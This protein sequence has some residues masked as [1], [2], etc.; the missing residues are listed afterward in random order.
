MAVPVDHLVDLDRWILARA[1][2]LGREL[3]QAYETY[4]FHLVYQKLHHFC[5]VD[6]GA[7][8]LDVLKDRLYTTPVAGQPRRS[9]QTALWHI[10]EAMVRWMAPI[11]SVTA[12]EIWTSLPPVADRPE[13]VFLSQWHP[14]PVVGA[15]TGIDWERVVGLRTDLTRA[16][17][18]LRT[19]GLI[20]APLEAAV[21]VYAE[22]AAHAGLVGL[23]DELRFALL[24]SRA[25]LHPASARPAD[26]IPAPAAGEGVYLAVRPSDGVK[27]VRCWHLS[28]DVGSDPAHP[29][30]CGR[31]ATNVGGAG[32]VRRWV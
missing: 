2:A 16:L 4:E 24:T 17:E 26:A 5:I 11:L 12:E 31:C 8:Y 15:S 1:H 27:C 29:E 9:A 3:E 19:Q 18:T 10:A 20:G 6:L 25:T 22:P 14:L 32:E 30:A 28:D 23:G 7:F 21:D 13:S